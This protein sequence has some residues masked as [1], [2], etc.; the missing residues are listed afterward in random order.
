MTNRTNLLFWMQR[1][2]VFKTSDIIRYGSENYSNRASRDARDFAEQGLIRRLSK[3]ELDVRGITSKEGVYVINEK[4]IK[5]YIQP[6]L[7]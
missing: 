6:K 5:N 2:K 1:K 3:F 4:A 7:F